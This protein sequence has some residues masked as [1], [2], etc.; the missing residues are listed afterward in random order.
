M[1]SWHELI[2]TPDPGS[3]RGHLHRPLHV[4]NPGRHRIGGKVASGRQPKHPSRGEQLSFDRANVV[5]ECLGGF[6]PLAA[7]YQTDRVIDKL[8]S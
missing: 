4:C 5:D 7:P 1:D 6:W 8:G 3:P 2:A